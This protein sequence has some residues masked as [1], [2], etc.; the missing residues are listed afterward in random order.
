MEASSAE[1]GQFL[2][3]TEEE[4]SGL[5]DAMNLAE[6]VMDQ[7]TEELDTAE[8]EDLPFSVDSADEP[9]SRDDAPDFTRVDEV[10]GGF[11]W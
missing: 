5:S 1:S 2:N 8:E 9:S 11:F 3:L 6:S 4:L 10:L 7:K